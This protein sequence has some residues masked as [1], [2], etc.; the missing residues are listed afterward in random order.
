MLKFGRE[1][2]NFGILMQLFLVFCT[3]NFSVNWMDRLALLTFATTT[4]QALP[5]S[6]CSLHITQA[7]LTTHKSVSLF[8][9]F[10]NYSFWSLE[11]ASSYHFSVR[12]SL[13]VSFVYI[14]NR[15]K[16]DS[17]CIIGWFYALLKSCT[18]LPDNTQLQS[19]NRFHVW[20]VSLVDDFFVLINPSAGS[21]P[22]GD[23]WRFFPSLWNLVSLLSYETRNW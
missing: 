9:L 12:Q 1:N 17:H 7:Q 20:K 11:L 14:L 5:S 16:F 21:G 4:I 8:S 3:R 18:I 13:V 2:L 6:F 10:L 19:A 22:F 15:H 23:Q